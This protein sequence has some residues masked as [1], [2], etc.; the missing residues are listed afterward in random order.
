[1]NIPILLNELISKKGSDLH[2]KVR[3]APVMR[4]HSKLVPYGDQSL[5]ENEILTLAKELLPES[6]HEEL[7]KGGELDFIFTSE[8]GERF[9]ANLFWQ[10]GEPSLAIR[11]VKKEIP[12]FKELQLPPQIAGIVDSPSGITLITG[13][14]GC[15]K[16]STLAAI[17]DYLNERKSWHIL[18]IEDPI[19]Y[20]F[21]DK[22]S[23]V[24]QREIGTDTESYEKALK[25]M[26]RQDPNAIV[27]GEMRDAN[28]FRA[29]LSAAETGHLVFSTLH[30]S[31]ASQSVTRI[32]DFFPSSEREQVRLQ[33]S[34]SL[35]AIICQKLIPTADKKG[36]I[37][38]VEILI[39]NG[40]VRKM[41]RENMLDKIPA[42]LEKGIDVGMQSFNRSLVYL[43]ETKAISVEE[44]MSHTSN[45]ETLKLNLQGVY[46]DEEKG[47]LNF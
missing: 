3:H 11:H 9:R 20:I 1:M 37:P 41:I 33:L 4:I 12:S 47:I 25:Y 46:L 26:L 15:G 16:S 39:A 36:R 40:M 6:R 42:A 35:N 23:I 28:S 5:D 18:T 27:I 24:N 21:E 17:V 38:A 29:A 14:T 2:L 8:K 19:E 13:P 7:V 31:N 34:Q 45:P 43:V 10:K 30:T 32:L 22:K 44:A